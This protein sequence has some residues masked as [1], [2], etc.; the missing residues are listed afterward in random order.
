VLRSTDAHAQGTSAVAFS[1][2]GRALASGGEEAVLKT[3]EVPA[4]RPLGVFGVPPGVDAAS[5]F[6]SFEGARLDIPEGQSSLRLL[7]LLDELNKGNVYLLR[8][9]LEEYGDPRLFAKASADEMA[10]A[11]ARVEAETGGLEPALVEELTERVVVVIARPRRGGA[12]RRVSLRLSEGEPQRI[13]AFDV[14]KAPQPAA[15]LLAPAPP[16]ADAEGRTTFRLNG[17]GGAKSVTLAGDFNGWSTSATPLERRG[18][19]WVAT[20]KLAPGRHV[21]KFVVD[22]R[23]LNDPGNPAREP[24]ASGNVN[25]LVVVK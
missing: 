17:F 1:P 7:E 4:L 9:V 2:D 25:S 13:I 24:D 22:G 21:Y 16:S 23:W 8:G 3:W 10:L 14:T 12:W 20:V 11:L 15:A 6:T 5:R 19:A 18:G